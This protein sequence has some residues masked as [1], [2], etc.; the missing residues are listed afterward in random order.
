MPVSLEPR[1]DERRHR[2]V[3]LEEAD[4]GA[5][6][7]QVP[8]EPGVVEVDDR[9][10]ALMHEQVRQP[11]V[12][13][14]QPV[15]LPP[16]AER[17]QPVFQRG[18]QAAE[19]LPLGGPDAQA[20]P[21]PPPARVSAERRV[22]VPREPGEPAR[23]RPGP[24]VPVHPRGNLAELS[25]VARRR[26]GAVRRG[27]LGAGE[28]LEPH[29]VPPRG[30]ALFGHGDHPPPVERG[31]HPGRAHARLGAQRVHPRQLRSD[32]GL[33]VVPQPVHPQHRAALVRVGDQERRVLRH[34]EQ[35]RRR[36]GMAPVRGE[37]VPRAPLDAAQHVAPGRQIMLAHGISLRSSRPNGRG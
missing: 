9:R 12:G 11:G 19:D 23:R 35:L 10:A 31:Q 27:G 25:E 16:G 29:A 5:E 24:R 7:V 15:P 6:V 33:G 28:E 8:A 34:G 17:G 14:H 18:L 1:R 2:G 22:R 20:V 3:V 32:R 13:V 26:R 37:R 36:R 30:G 4:R 21:P